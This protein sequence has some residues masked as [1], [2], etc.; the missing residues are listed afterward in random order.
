MRRTGRIAVLAAGLAVAVAGCY[1]AADLASGLA[2]ARGRHRRSVPLP[3]LP[4]HLGSGL[5]A[6]APGIQYPLSCFRPRPG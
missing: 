5:R 3:R 4:G 2:A 1:L 6:V